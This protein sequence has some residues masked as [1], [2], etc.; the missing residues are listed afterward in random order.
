MLSKLFFCS[1]KDKLAN[2]KQIPS[3]QL[4]LQNWTGGTKNISKPLNLH[5]ITSLELML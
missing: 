3:A 5:F 4:Q 1:D 2:T